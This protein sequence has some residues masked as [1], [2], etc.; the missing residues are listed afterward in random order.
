MRIWIFN[1][2]ACRRHGTGLTGHAVMAYYMQQAGHQ[3]T[4]F[5]ASFAQDYAPGIEIPPGE[6]FVDVMDEGVR[7]RYV[8]T[9]P[10]RG[11][12]TRLLNMYHYARNACR[13]DEGLATPEVVIG[14]LSHPYA[15]EA[16]FRQAR[17]HGAT[18]VYEIR[19]I[20]PQSLIDLGSLPRWH[21]ICWHFRWLERRAFA[22]A[23]GVLSVLPKIADYAVAHGVP[24]DRVIYI[25]NGIDPDLFPEP[26]DPPPAEPFLIACFGRFGSGNDMETIVEAAARLAADPAGRGIRIR[27]VGDGPAKQP[28]VEK[29]ARQGLE[30]LQFHDLVTK[31]ELAEMSQQ[32]HAFVHAHRKMTVVRRYGMSVNK[33]FNFMASARP[34]VFACDSCYD[35]IQEARAGVT[36]PPEDPAAMA[37]A[38]IRLRDTAEAERIAMGRRAR[39]FVLQHHDLSKAAG[40]LA[41]FFESLCQRSGTSPRH[42]AHQ[43]CQETP[44]CRSTP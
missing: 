9:T 33:V 24:S 40:R 10:Y 7:F 16:G 6:R 35:P 21:P 29:A 11:S 3:V 34:V 23:D 42:A 30:N 43:P 22:Q 15:V 13:A 41:D 19:D 27:L 37:E 18:F 14:S 44:P 26:P 28:L 36:V 17:R 20:W 2:Y 32:C 31:L 38:M 4:L 8:R 1:H 12:V 39:E 5:P 25:P